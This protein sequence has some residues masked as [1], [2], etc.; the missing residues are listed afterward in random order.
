MDEVRRQGV[1]I[2]TYQPNEEEIEAAIAPTV[3]TDASLGHK[4]AQ[5]PQKY[6]VEVPISGTVFIDVWAEDER[7]ARYL[8]IKAANDCLRY[9]IEQSGVRNL[10]FHTDLAANMLEPSGG[11]FVTKLCVTNSSKP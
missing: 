10:W 2:E 5:E 1:D 7:G 4:P 3:L 6:T 8:G 9:G 11:P